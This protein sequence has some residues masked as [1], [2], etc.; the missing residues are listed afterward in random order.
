MKIRYVVAA[1]LWCLAGCK[2]ENSYDPLIE[3]AFN[4]PMMLRYQQSA[5]L[6]NQSAPELTVRI[7]TLEEYRCPSD[8]TCHWEG[9]ARV[10]LGMQDRSGAKQSLVLKLRGLST[11]IDSTA[12][13]ANGQR[14]VLVLHELNP[15]PSRAVKDNTQRHIVLSVKR[16]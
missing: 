14:Y 2:K 12:V 9:L 6:P 4:Q 7:D 11:G 16:R 8:V 5:A 1:S 10:V 15:Y 3:A 13:Q